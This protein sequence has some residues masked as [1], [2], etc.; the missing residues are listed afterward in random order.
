L[1]NQVGIQSRSSYGPALNV[2]SRANS[3]N[4]LYNFA[5]KDNL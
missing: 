3:I 5:S 1:Q 4:H 2:N